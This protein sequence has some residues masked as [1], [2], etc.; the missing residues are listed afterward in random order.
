MKKILIVEDD[1]VLRENTAEFIR[2]EGYEVFVA[3]D[4]I[5]GVQQALAH[6]PDLILCDI[7]MPKMNG[8][9][10]YKTIQQIQIT[11]TIPLIYFSA[12]TEK[13]DIRSGMQ[14]GA[15]DYITKPFDFM[16][17]LRVIKIRLAKHQAIAKFHDEKFYALIDNPSLGVFIYQ[18]G[19][20]IFY[21]SKLAAI[22][23][24]TFEEFAKIGFNDLIGDS[25]LVKSKVINDI[26]KCMRDL[27]NTISLQFVTVDKHARLL[28]VDLF[29][30]V[31]L[32]KGIQ[33]LVGNISPVAD[34][35]QGIQSKIYK[36]ETLSK[37]SPREIK[38]L[39]LV[40]LGNS[41]SEISEL[42]N[43]SNR[44]IETYRANL[45]IKTTC[46]NVAELVMFALRH[47]FVNIT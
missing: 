11:S 4:G 25:L 14:L 47:R 16:N 36:D 17:L 46:K 22:F 32:Y 8:F 38:V 13:E 42:L 43:L 1:A 6:V 33:S 45:L 9:E 23:G 5:I 19:T 35:F 27:N 28:N 10:F 24:Y 12:R 40:C 18:N 20:F 26:D 34:E 3:E 41:T 44:T 15:D 37:L 2:G 21:S 30:T 31:I 29:G 39:E 7:A